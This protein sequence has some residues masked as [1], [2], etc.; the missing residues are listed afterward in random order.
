[1]TFGDRI[2]LLIAAARWMQTSVDSENLP[3]AFLGFYTV[4]NPSW[5]MRE[6][7]LMALLHIKTDYQTT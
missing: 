3:G 5:I 2:L 1:M 6:R 7:V 4:Y